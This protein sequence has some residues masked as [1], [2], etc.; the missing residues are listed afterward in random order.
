LAEALGP[1]DLASLRA[2]IDRLAADVRDSSVIA[3][4]LIA[5]VDE[6][7]ALAGWDELRRRLVDARTRLAELTAVYSA[8]NLPDIAALEERAQACRDK[9][10][11]LAVAARA[12]LL[13]RDVIDDVKVAVHKSFLPAMNAALGEALGAI[14]SGKYVEANL[15][16]ADFAVRLRSTER[17]GTVD[18]WQLSSGTTEQVNLALRAATAQ[19]LGGGEKV[20]LILDDALAHAD[21][22][23]AAGAL[24]LLA[25]GGRRGL[26]TLL[27]TQRADLVAL[28]RDL[29]GVA[30]VDLEDLSTAHLSSSSDESAPSGLSEAA[31][32]GRSAG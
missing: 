6:K 23:R 28:A 24:A 8:A 5:A 10:R 15:N 12:A 27:F 21:S 22:G 32:L 13:A 18:P 4:A 7:A 11:R 17:G 25:A 30:V 31:G 9:E 16:P 2:E 1:F 3:P 19:A 14:T 29:P 26:Q 20:P